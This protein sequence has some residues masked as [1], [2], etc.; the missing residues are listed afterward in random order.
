MCPNLSRSYPMIKPFLYNF[1]DVRQRTGYE[2]S[3]T[4]KPQILQ[5]ILSSMEIRLNYNGP[6]TV[7]V[8]WSYKKRDIRLEVPQVEKSLEEVSKLR[9]HFLKK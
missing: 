8:H 2:M 5:R 3:M 6:L 9:R 1:C 7:Q 4:S